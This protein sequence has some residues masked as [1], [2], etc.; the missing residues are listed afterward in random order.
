MNGEEGLLGRLM[1]AARPHPPASRA[2]SPASGE[3]KHTPPAGCAGDLPGVKHAPPARFAGDL[4]SK[5]GGEKTKSPEPWLGAFLVVGLGDADALGARALGARLD[6]ERNLLATLQ[7]IEVAL[8]A[9]AVEEVFLSVL[10][11]DE[12]KATIRNQLFDSACGHY[13]LL[14][15]ERRGLLI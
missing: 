13:H 10:G 3:V 8:G 14:S 2:T 12:S 5:W 11:L 7:P 4:P 6:F 9:T 1:T 15:L